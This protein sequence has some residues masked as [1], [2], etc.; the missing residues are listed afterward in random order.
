MTPKQLVD[1]Q[2]D[3]FKAVK[4]GHAISAKAAELERLTASLN[5]W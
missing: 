1:L 4:L 5:N 2:A 3:V